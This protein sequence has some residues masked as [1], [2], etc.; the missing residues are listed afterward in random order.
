M[1][2]GRTDRRLPGLARAASVASLAGVGGSNDRPAALEDRLYRLRLA[3]E[4]EVARVAVEGDRIE[5]VPRLETAVAI[6][7]AAQLGRPGC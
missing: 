5:R 2:P 6:A 1:T 4:P 3:E 7:H